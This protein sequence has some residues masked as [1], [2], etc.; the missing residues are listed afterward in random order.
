MASKRYFKATT[1]QQFNFNPYFGRWIRL[2]TTY[3]HFNGIVERATDDAVLL[4]MPKSTL[5]KL[6]SSPQGNLDLELAG[7]GHEHGC[8]PYPY[9]VCGP[10]WWCWFPIIFI[11]F[12]PFFFW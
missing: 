9:R 10:W 11:I 2:E 1:S 4:K 5:P 6:T 8:Y 3:G 12:I 7:C